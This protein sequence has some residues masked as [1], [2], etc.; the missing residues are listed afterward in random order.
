V[1]ASEWRR[2]VPS[3]GTSPQ[4]RS[5]TAR[6]GFDP[7]VSLSRQELEACLDQLG[8]M[9]KALD[10][11]DPE[12]LSQLYASLRLSLTYCHIEQI[13]DVEVDP[14]GDR[15]DKYRVRGG[16]RSLTTRLKLNV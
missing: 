16:T 3:P 8:D 10:K 5:S 15:V 14:M 4:E 11:A 7:R 1:T 6:V 13:V 9:A 2:C 12:E